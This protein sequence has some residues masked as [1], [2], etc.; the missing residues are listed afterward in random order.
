MI[1]AA[2]DIMEYFDFF[3]WVLYKS[4]LENCKDEEISMF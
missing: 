3:P 1:C 4:E 2:S